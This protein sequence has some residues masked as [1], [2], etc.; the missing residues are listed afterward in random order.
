ME[1]FRPNTFILQIR[2]QN[3]YC[4]HDV[5]EIRIIMSVGNKMLITRNGIKK[6]IEI[7]NQKVNLIVWSK[8]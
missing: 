5:L 2:L 7:A 4:L 1:S 6:M 3:A 8:K